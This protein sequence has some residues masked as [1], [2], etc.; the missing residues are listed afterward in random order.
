MTL[1]RYDTAVSLNGFIADEQNSLSWLFAVDGSADPDPDLLPAD[2]GAVVI[3]STT[4]EWLLAEEDLLQHPERWQ[5][6]SD[7]RPVFVFTSRTLAVPAGA[8]VVFCSGPVADSLPAIRHA[9]GSGDVWVMGGGD[10]AG[11]FWD[12]GALDEIAVTIAPAL[13]GGGAPLFPRR[14]EADRLRLVEARQ[15]GA[16]ARLVYRIEEPPVPAS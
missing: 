5:N 4:Y 2:V 6:V 8:D 3:G 1:F 14:V 10:L 11:Q 13:L 9:A 16:F 7:G 15:A 12:T